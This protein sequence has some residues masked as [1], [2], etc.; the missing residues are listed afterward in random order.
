MLAF[1]TALH[2]YPCY[3]EGFG[4]TD[5]I[6]ISHHAAAVTNAIKLQCSEIGDPL[7]PSIAGAQPPLDRAAAEQAISAADAEFEPVVPALLLGAQGPA[8]GVWQAIVGAKVDDD[9]GGDTQTKT[10]TWQLAHGLPATGVVQEADLIA[11]GLML[12]PTTLDSNS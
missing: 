1:S 8:V 5:A 4:A 7:P 12:K 10:R 6:R 3:Y 2:Q 11:A 9:F